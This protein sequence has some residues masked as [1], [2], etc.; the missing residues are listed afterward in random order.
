MRAALRAELRRSA[1]LPPL[2]W[3]TAGGVLLAVGVVL[4]LRQSS[5]GAP[6]T[7]VADLSRGVVQ[8]AAVVA[9]A[10]LGAAEWPHR[11]I[12]W[13]AVPRRIVWWASRWMVAGVATAF[14]AALLTAASRAPLGV[15]D[16]WPGA[17]LWLWAVAMAA[18][19]AA[20]VTRSVLA[21]SVAVLAVLWIAPGLL[22]PFPAAMAWLPDAT[23]LGGWAGV[24]P[25]VG[26]G[27]LI[28]VASAAAL[29][30]WLSGSDA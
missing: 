16:G 11:S 27:W 5:G 7:A 29:R 4:L 23:P 8:A 15:L 21:G 20:E 18:H 10:V 2:G 9:G 1:T 14:V 30:A 6:A 3:A 28:A 25:G 22:R 13:L 26:V 24:R 12:A 19:L 17:W